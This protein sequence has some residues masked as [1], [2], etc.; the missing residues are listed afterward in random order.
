MKVW[1]V[2]ELTHGCT[3]CVPLVLPVT[4]TLKD[5]FEEDGD[6]VAPSLLT[7]MVAVLDMHRLRT[8]INGAA[9]GRT[10]AVVHAGWERRRGD[11]P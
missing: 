8:C 3:F 11:D 7:A 9:V 5:F 4:N 6:D 2:H 10:V 1:Y